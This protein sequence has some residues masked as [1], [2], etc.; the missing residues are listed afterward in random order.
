VQKK[1]LVIEGVHPSPLSAHKGFFGSKNFSK[2][3]EYL[4]EHG[5]EPIDW[6]RLN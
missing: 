1:H 3:N 5:K 2:C 4:L 6:T